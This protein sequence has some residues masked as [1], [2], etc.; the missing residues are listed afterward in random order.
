M[1]SFVLVFGLA[2][3]SVSNAGRPGLVGYWRLNETTGTAVGDASGNNNHGTLEGGA[4]WT[5][6]KLDGGVYLDGVDDYIEVP[7]LIGEVGSK[8]TGTMSIYTRAYFSAPDATAVKTLT[9]K[10]DYDDACVMWLNR[11]EIARSESQLPDEPKSIAGEER[12][13]TT[14]ADIKSAY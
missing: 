1:V 14:W 5:T 4:K 9:L 11:V 3:T 8:A 12:L 6:G 13:S 2:L 10:V 7:N